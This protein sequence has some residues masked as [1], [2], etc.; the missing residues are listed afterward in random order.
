VLRGVVTA[1]D[2]KRLEAH[3]VVIRGDGFKL[4]FEFDISLL[5][6]MRLEEKQEE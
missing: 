3:E 5:R 6:E 4:D 2:G 1:P